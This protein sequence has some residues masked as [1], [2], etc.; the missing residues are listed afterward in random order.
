MRR[1]S[2]LRIAHTE[3]KH[4]IWKQSLRNR[5]LKLSRG[6]SVARLI[7]LLEG[8]LFQGENIQALEHDKMIQG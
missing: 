7:L 4:F 5:A 2:V 8:D 6:D 1:I 3:L